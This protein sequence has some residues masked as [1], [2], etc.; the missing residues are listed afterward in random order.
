MKIAM[1]LLAVANAVLLT[2]LLTDRY[3]EHRKHNLPPEDSVKRL[4]F[5]DSSPTNTPPPAEAPSPE[6]VESTPAPPPEA[7]CS[8]LEFNSKKDRE[9][10]EAVL[11][12]A[13]RED[14]RWQQSSIFLE[15][16]YY[17]VIIPVNRSLKQ[18]R[19]ISQT[20]K[21]KNIDNYILEDKNNSA[22]SVALYKTKATATKQVERLSKLVPQYTFTIVPVSTE[23]PALI[24]KSPNPIDDN[25]LSKAIIEYSKSEQATVQGVAPD[26]WVENGLS[27]LLYLIA[28]QL[29]ASGYR[30]Q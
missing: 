16:N 10:M 28:C 12:A 24:L 8:Q 13:D 29:V 23:L 3:L 1:L 19:S 21:K 5:Y 18:A 14:L 20:L 9:K 7:Y 22:I 26:P 17:R 25:D 15:N 27:T 11:Q 4:E 30:G 6:P 2:L